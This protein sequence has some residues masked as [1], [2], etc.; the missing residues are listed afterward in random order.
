M[1][2]QG[3]NMNNS[4]EILAP[5]GSP[6]A[7][8]AAVL[9][10]A[11]AVYLGVKELNVVKAQEKPDG[12]FPTTPYPNPENADVFALG[13]ELADDLVENRNGHGIIIS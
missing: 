13:A 4:T 9:C 7:L 2:L 12:N 5:A 1:S 8:R 10:G 3:I 6:E 11:D